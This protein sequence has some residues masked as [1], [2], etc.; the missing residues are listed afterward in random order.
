M[1]LEDEMQKCITNL[2][3]SVKALHIATQELNNAADN[4][5]RI[6]R[7]KLEIVKT[8]PIEAALTKGVVDSEE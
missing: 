5:E 4:L 1:S 8:N 7:P 2:A 6:Q 3:N